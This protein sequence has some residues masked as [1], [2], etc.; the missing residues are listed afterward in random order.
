MENK[1]TMKFISLIIFILIQTPFLPFS[2]IGYIIFEYKNRLVS[3]K[4]GVSA[5]AVSALAGKYMS[6]LAGTHQNN[7]AGKLYTVLPNASV[8]GFWLLFFPSY[9]R[10]KICPAQFK[11]GKETMIT[12]ANRSVYF[13]RMIEKQKN[14]VEQFV[15]MGAG[16]D[17]RPYS[18]LKNSNLKFFE[19][20]QLNTQKLKIES[21]K[22][23]NMDCSHVTFVDVDFTTEKWYEKL[24]KSGYNPARKTL[25]LWEGVTAYLCENDVR[26]TINEIKLHSAAGSVLTTDFYAHRIASRKRVKETNEMLYFTLDFSGNAANVLKSFIESENLTLGDFYFMGHK[27]S[28]KGAIGVVIEIIL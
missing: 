20:D 25:F 16:F 22:K 1:N 21:L 24:E 14:N 11:A 18:E 8:A 28:S 9:V 13:D 17:T 7:L 19:L 23:A 3:K 15:I 10:Y 27:A 4:L 12:I 5:T 6:A 2:I 26:K